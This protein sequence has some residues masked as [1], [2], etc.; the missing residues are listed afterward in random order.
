MSWRSAFLRQAR[1]EQ[2]VRRRLNDPAVE[3]CHR[4]HYLQMVSEKLAKGFLTREGAAEPPAPTH[5]A[6][7]RLLQVLK[8]RRDIRERLGYDAH[9]FKVYIDSLL[10]LANRVEQLAPSA[11]GFTQPNPEYPWRDVATGQVLAPVDFAFP[12]FDPRDPKMIKLEKLIEWLVE[13]AE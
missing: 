10:Q 13:V 6:F 7:V 12:L 4:L 2:E 8:S 3:Y 11:A 1:R 9:T 5:L